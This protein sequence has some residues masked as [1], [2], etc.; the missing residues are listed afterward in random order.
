MTIADLLIG[1]ARDS[2]V[3]KEIDLK[4]DPDIDKMGMRK[5]YENFIMPL[6]ELYLAIETDGML[7]DESRREVLL[8][9]Y[10][11]WS[12][13]LSYERYQLAG[14]KT[15]NPQS[16]QQ[17][18][19]FLYEHLNCPVE[20]EQVKKFLHLCIIKLRKKYTKRYR[21]YTGLKTS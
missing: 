11:E 9:K 19:W 17:V 2:C 1:C 14:N 5:Y 4:M 6:H 20:R 3:T 12:E 10:I 21:Q 7:V 8:Q 15:V 18:R 16:W 13:K